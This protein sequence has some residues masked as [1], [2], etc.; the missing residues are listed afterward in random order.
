[1]NNKDKNT[2]PLSIFHPLV[3]K[4]FSEKVGIP[5]DIQ[6]KAWPQIQ[7]GSN[8]LIT[9]PTG[10]GKTLT[11]FLWAIN[12]IISGALTGGQ[13]R[14]LY[15]SPLK[16][17]NNDVRQNLLKPIDELGI[18]FKE[19]GLDF[20]EI[21]VLTRS[22]DTPEAERRRMFKHPPEILI[23][24]PE[25]I[26]ILLSS[27]KS[28]SILTGIAV[29][30][31][32]EIHAVINSKRGTHLITAID[33]L[34][35]LCGE[36]Q[37]IALSATVKPVETVADFT[38]GYIMK[39][40]AA[41]ESYRKRGVSIISSGDI[42]HYRVSVRF[43]ENARETMIDGSRWSA[44]IPSFKEII[45]KNKSTLFFANSRRLAEKVTR[46]I[47]EGEDKEFAYSHHGSLSREIRLAVEQKLKNGDLKA[48]VATSSLELGI[49][50]G[51]LDNVVLIQ[52]PPAIS[53]AIQRI[54]R[55]GH[56]VG[57]I[58]RGII[59][60]VHGHDF[61][62][63]AIIAR[64]VMDQDIEAQAPVECPLDVLAQVII[65]MTGVEIWDIDE[66]YAFIKTSY[67]YRN[68]PRR[69]FD[70]VLEMLAGR[71]AGSNIRELK[72]R[73]FMD[74]IDNTVR[75]K[76]GALRL[77]YMSGGTIP[78]RGY[79]DLRVQESHAKIGE[80]DEEFVW[81]RSIGETF[82]LGAQSW[83]IQRITHNDV[84][85][86]PAGSK[87]GIFPFWR[88]EEQDRDFYFSEKIS[89]FLEHAD[90]KI[91]DPG[92]KDELRE[93]YFME[94]A[95]ADELISFLRL[96]R[97]ITRA[98]LPHRRH[99]L[100]EHFD[101]PFNKSDSKQVILHTL[102]GGRVNRPVAFAIASSWEEKYGYPLETTANND[103]IML[104]LPHE[105]SSGEIFRLINPENL[106]YHLRRKLES[107]GFFGA[108]FRESAGRALLL[109]RS[110]FKKRLPLWLNRLRSKKLMDAVTDFKDFPIFIEAWRTCIKDEFDIESAKQVLHEI[111]SG[112]TALSETITNSA[113]PFA[114]KLIWKQ[115][116]TYMYGDD[117]PNAQRTS[118]LSQELLKEVVQSSSLRPRIPEGL[119]AILESK[120]KR[121]A[122]DY[123]PDSPDELLEW[124]KKRILIPEKE[125][126]ELL[127]SINRD[128]KNKEG[129]IILPIAE[130]I[131]WLSL[132]GAP[133][134]SICALETLQSIAPLFN[135]AYETIAG[136]CIKDDG[137]ISE[138]VDATI[139]T[140][141]QSLKEKIP[142]QGEE[143]SLT[144]VLAQWLSFYGPLDKDSIKN[145][146]GI[147]DASLDVALGSMAL[148]QRIII[149]ILREGSEK[150]EI[151]DCENLETLLRMARR[152]RQPS[153]QAKSLEYL[154]LFF[155]AF[156]GLTSQ[157]D[158][159][160]GLQDCL[161]Q[162]FGYPAQ[163][164]AWEEYI[165]PAR[166]HPYYTA[167]LDSLM[168]SSELLWFGCGNKRTSFA[169]SDDL[170]L[171]NE[172][173]PVNNGAAINTESVQISPQKI[174]FIIPDT[175]GK[176]SF[177]DI[178][179]HSRMDSEYASMNLWQLTWQGRITNDS[180]SA[181]RKGILNNFTAS[182]IGTDKNISRRSGYNRWASTRPV[183][184]NWYVLDNGS[185]DSDAQ[186]DMEISKDRVRQLFARYGILFRE[187]VSNELPLLQWRL[188]FKTLR[189][190]ELSGEILSGYFF[191]NI[192]GAQ[193]IS[194]DAFRFLNTPLPEDS[195][196]WINAADPASMC[197]IK[198]DGLKQVLPSRLGSTYLVFRGKK[199]ALISKRNH[200]ALE[201]K[202]PPDDPDLSNFLSFFK[203]MLSRD[204]NP[205]RI[206]LVE[207]INELPA[208]ESE[209]AGPM[210]KFGFR[211]HYK[212]LELVKKF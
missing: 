182:G 55:S 125:W 62:E 211:A 90:S 84:E 118:G 88:A 203:V 169:F 70:L 204:F 81:E 208:N 85:V 57:D 159:I 172:S 126:I 80:L 190:M 145:V 165:L 59:Y 8:V 166:I 196:Y 175:G 157:A 24:T 106:E 9:S 155:A 188:I 42:K 207:S 63:A 69:Q 114:G 14:V 212:G 139:K 180:Y 133:A 191:E 37:R 40:N 206:I 115:T 4:W 200:K 152:S 49:D 210:K 79:F 82:T 129:D 20:P 32:D 209:Y 15:V 51:S 201:F 140:I 3:R 142:E 156:Q 21:N 194:H 205:E 124:I 53:A 87:T 170:E 73:I 75:A 48:I 35:G 192:P 54:G 105:F 167:W 50:I 34:V 178:L 60:P 138:K 122:P 52:T 104:M 173:I 65:S 187:L 136:R 146:F 29:V 92:F 99:V 11:A 18:Y 135:I 41:S 30:I 199:L 117:S 89:V 93:K 179:S 186:R 174:D 151:C 16:A 95:A 181:L 17:L 43:P 150:I 131:I 61:I 72:S 5:T 38:G 148:E 13:T 143:I 123:A 33:R 158:S 184:G 197:G 102:W 132:P 176:F 193:F 25:S 161:D 68:L 108:R 153:F 97:E 19:A 177:F 36:F 96:Q 44:L 149:D 130:K 163:A 119:I 164:G 160:S 202:T 6:A 147:D 47:N 162:L 76:E 127:A 185:A 2:D 154:P 94:N 83:R 198:L 31:M 77:I 27:V 23:T 78:D 109:P 103:C 86:V 101:D 141:F 183:S 113:S 111:I 91:D 121:T 64:S 107:T 134:Q 56:S 195:I 12:Q 71:Y 58:S 45:S 74:R 144:D 26:N 168:Q 100:I 22:G 171:F 116:N 98:P 112:E 128:N 120:L 28:R 67:P 46:L 1:M 39:G 110:G 7:S 137:S 66:L 10:S 189:L